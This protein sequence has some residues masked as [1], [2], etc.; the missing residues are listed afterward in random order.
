MLPINEHSSERK[1]ETLNVRVSPLRG[2]G[3]VED[4]VAIWIQVF[5]RQVDVRN[6][7]GHH[8]EKKIRFSL[9]LET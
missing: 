4:V 1:E 7:I 6:V 5:S 9:F 2:E 3:Y 8:L